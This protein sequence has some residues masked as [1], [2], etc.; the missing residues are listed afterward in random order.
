MQ[1]PKQLP[2]DPAV[3][4]VTRRADVVERVKAPALLHDHVKRSPKKHVLVFV[5]GF[6]NKF[7]GVLKALACDPPRP[8][9]A[10]DQE[11]AA[12]RPRRRRRAHPDRRHGSEQAG[13]RALRAFRSDKALALPADLHG[14]PDR[15]GSI[16]PLKPDDRAMLEKDGVA[17]FDPSQI[18]KADNLNHDTF[19]TNPEIVGPIGTRLAAGQSI[20][21]A[22]Q[23]FSGTLFNGTSGAVSTFGNA[24]GLIVSAPTA[25]FN[26]DARDTYG[27][28]FRSFRTD[29]FGR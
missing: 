27:D 9:R 19:A 23:H 16:D 12:R 14:A 5:H 6:N 7:E 3:D 20:A 24:A 28:R 17:V 11:R 4:F 22:K 15:L 25:A 21:E 10:E 1:W 18:N 8:D 26:A 13:L 29:I 2:G